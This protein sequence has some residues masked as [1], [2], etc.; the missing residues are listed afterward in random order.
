MINQDSITAAILSNNILH[1]DSTFT[2]VS[3]SITDAVF[4]T[5]CNQYTMEIID[6]AVTN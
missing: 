3:L 1:T 5:Q 2:T 4:T 6:M